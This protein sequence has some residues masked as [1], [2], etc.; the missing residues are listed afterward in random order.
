MKKYLALILAI[1]LNL[2]A[3]SQD[4][5]KLV[6]TIVVDQCKA[7]YLNRFNPYFEAGGFDRFFMQGYTF[8]NVHYNYAPTYTGPG[9][10]SLFTGATPS[11]HGI[12][13]NDWYDPFLKRSV[14][15]VEDD[16]VEPVGT[17]DEGFKRSPA[18]L[19]ATTFSDELKWSQ[20]SNQSYAISI[21]DRSAILSGGHT[22]DG[23]FWFDSETGDFGSSSFYGE[24]LPQWLSDF[25][26]KDL[27]QNYMKETWELSVESE[28]YEKWGS[29]NS[30]FEMQLIPG[31]PTV[32]PYDLNKAAKLSSIKS[33]PYGNQIIVDLAKAVVNGQDLGSGESTDY[34]AVN[35][36]A[37]DYVGHAFGPRSW[38]VMDTYI[39]LDAQLEELF[40]F[41]DSKLG[42]G[43][44]V[45]ALSSDHGAAENSGFMN[46]QNFE[47][48]ALDM[49]SI[50]SS[51]R[52]WA[53]EKGHPEIIDKVFSDRIYLDHQEMAK[54]KLSYDAIY[55]EMESLLF[56]LPYVHSVYNRRKLPY[57]SDNDPVGSK[58][59]AGCQ[60]PRAG[61]ILFVMKPGYMVYSSK[62]TTHGSVWN[63]DT[64]VPILYYGWNIPV[65]KS[66]AY[67]PITSLAPTLSHL[68]G[69]ALPS[70]AFSS[71]MTEVLNEK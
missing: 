56:T 41:L 17:L 14:Y 63:Y 42:K 10:A 62:G 54:L 6:V 45:V 65:G 39:K 67:Y 29:D 44:Y 66:Y 18:N 8:E 23:A 53:E 55:A 1:F 50:E 40:S 32:F 33:T 11:V 69:T 46:S 57:L 25:N 34:L 31:A 49:I 61:D 51:I 16:A 35:F 58:I 30:P 13:E 52:D 37:T 24:A 5:P 12:I 21:K 48:T 2:N 71:P 38:E 70:G 64:H 7:E 19:N 22:A 26:A 20:G 15:C 59:K 36:S 28:E 9:H 60:D 3:F 43:T 47:K 27:P 68:L 4:K